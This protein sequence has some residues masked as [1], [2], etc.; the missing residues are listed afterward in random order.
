MSDHDS[1]KTPDAITIAIGHERDRTNT[2]DFSRSVE[3]A[4]TGDHD[5][6]RS[7]LRTKKALWAWLILC[8][9]VGESLPFGILL[10]AIAFLAT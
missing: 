1:R 3:S 9:S 7:P 5:K 2:T 4:P 10:S 8:Y 6:T